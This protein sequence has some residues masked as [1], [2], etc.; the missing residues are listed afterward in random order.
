MNVSVRDLEQGELD[1]TF[2]ARSRHLSATTGPRAQSPAAKP[3][4]TKAPQ[5]FNGIHRR[6]RKKIMW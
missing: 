4:R 3:Q 1:L 2:L 6:R 5:R